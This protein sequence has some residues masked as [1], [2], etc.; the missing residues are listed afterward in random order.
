MS[1][2]PESATVPEVAPSAATAPTAAND[3]KRTPK[4]TDE[5][6]LAIVRDQKRQAVGM[7][8]QY[9]LS[10]QRQR[11]LE[12]YKGEMTDISS[13]SNRS[14]A[15]STDVQ[16]AVE[17]V[18]PDLVDIFTGGED[19][20]T[21]SPLHEEDENAAK[22]ETDY[23]VHVVTKDNPWFLVCYGA[24]KDAL[25]EKIGL[26]HWWWE[27]KSEEYEERF[28][29]K[30]A[31]E[32]QAAQQSCVMDGLEMSDVEQDASVPQA[33][34]TFSF[35]LSKTTNKGR[36][37]IADV[38]PDDFSVAIDT[39][40]LQDATYCCMRSRPRVQDLIADGY[41]RE[42]VEN[43]PP[44]GGASQSENIERARDTA[45]E[46]LNTPYA[47]AYEHKDLR[48]V[49]ILTHFIRVDACEDGQPTLWKVVSGN[50]EMEF[51]RKEEVNRI[52]FSAITPFLTPHRFHGRSLAD[53]LMEVQRIKTALLRML[54]DSG[55]FAINQRHEVATAPGKANQFTVSD[56][57]NNIP[58]APIRSNDGQSVRPLTSGGLGFDVMSALEYVSTLG[59]QRSGV[60][61]S[62]QGLTP[63]TLHD[64]ASGALAML[65]NAAK[66][67]RLIA[68]IF[69][70]TGVKDMFL[71]VHA[72]LR[73]NATAN[74][75]F[76]VNRQWIPVDPS[77]WGERDDMEIEVGVGS[78][79]T[80][81]DIVALNMLAGLMEKVVQ[82][83]GGTQGPF[84]VPEGLY[85]LL[86]KYQDKLRVKGQ[87]F[88]DPA[89][90]QPQPKGPD[91]KAMEVQAKAQADQAK[92][93]IEQGKLQLDQQRFA[94]E[95][96][97]S[98][99]EQARK[100]E[101]M[102]F[103]QQYR[104][105]ELEQTRELTLAEIDA[106]YAVAT[107][108]ARIKAEADG[109][110]IGADMTMDAAKR[111]HDLVKGAQEAQNAK[112][113]MAHEAAHAHVGKVV[114]AALRP[115]ATGEIDDI[116]G[117]GSGEP[118]IGEQT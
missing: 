66:R 79:G 91:P 52:P 58:G 5:Q 34:P 47:V 14:K 43:L 15:V 109:L 99:K 115:P 4:L 51:L 68:R 61:R 39:I 32:F 76:R 12:Y 113:L 82:M 29:G 97:E 8:D 70:E 65:S 56:L 11:A 21:F 2:V 95:Q 71:G 80:Q 116:K 10:A 78:G 54:L 111:G 73:E 27:D 94:L 106:K 50:N 13:L 112:E 55:L 74:A 98:A 104:L 41:D 7:E 89:A 103:D 93:Q 36:V 83:Q 26:F 105:M 62:V 6:F 69:S 37:R 45:G 19:I 25:L 110:R 16:E 9:E 64:T 46:H 114:D 57:I 28:T 87:F 22:L 108:A 85:E 84:V 117:P 92:T 38:A 53:V 42:S 118:D 17:T 30:T 86:Q 107:D 88:A 77:T 63:D 20:A 3:T 48:Q 31:I 40:R 101:D 35:T 60:I 100:D 102:S 1:V 24:M 23:V 18:L 96:Q 44:Y 81:Q 75:K 33:M 67:I 59:E 49:E 72:T 90:Q